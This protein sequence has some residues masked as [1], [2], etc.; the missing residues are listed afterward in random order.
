MGRVLVEEEKTGWGPKNPGKWAEP[1]TGRLARG[2]YTVDM[3]MNFR[4]RYKKEESS[5]TA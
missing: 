3:N 5:F 4:I 1:S 2:C